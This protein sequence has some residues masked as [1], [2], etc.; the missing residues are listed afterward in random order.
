[1]IYFFWLA[2][3]LVWTIYR[4]VCGK[5]TQPGGQLPRFPS[6]VLSPLNSPSTSSQLSF[7]VLPIYS[8]SRFW[9]ATWS[10]LSNWVKKNPAVFHDVEAFHDLPNWNDKIAKLKQRGSIGSSI[11]HC[12]RRNATKGHEIFVWRT[13]LIDQLLH[14]MLT[15]WCL[16]LSW[17]D[18]EVK[19]SH[20]QRLCY[21]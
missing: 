13:I 1:M 17:F 9:I 7:A 2:Y 3:L 10:P 19:K 18:F 5:H 11:A 12:E 6:T 4:V 21:L 16:E 14:L 15:E 20:Y 8:F